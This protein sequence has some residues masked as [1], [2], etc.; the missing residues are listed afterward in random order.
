MGRGIALKEL[1]RNEQALA[2]LDKAISIEPNDPVALLHRGLTLEEMQRNEEAL[3]AYNQ[4]IA[5][6]ATFAPAIE[7]RSKLQQKLGL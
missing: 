2:A 5:A 6:D 1:K 7:A 3:N 4:A